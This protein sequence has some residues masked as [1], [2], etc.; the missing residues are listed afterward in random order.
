M[1]NQ[2]FIKN[3]VKLDTYQNNHKGKSNENKTI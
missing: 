2:V 3:L 1:I